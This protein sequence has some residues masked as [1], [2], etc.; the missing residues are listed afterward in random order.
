MVEFSGICLDL[1]DIETNTYQVEPKFLM[2]ESR[3]VEETVYSDLLKSNCL[4]TG[5][6]D[7]GSVFFIHYF[8]PKIDHCGLLKYLISFRNHS[9]FG[10]HCVEQIFNDITLQCRPEQ[11]TV[12][13]RYTRRGGLDINPFRSNFEKAPSNLRQIRQ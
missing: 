2:T 6:P 3:K 11:L 1:L 4:A 13:A 8:G 12:Y 5:Q 10:E 9:G 7:W